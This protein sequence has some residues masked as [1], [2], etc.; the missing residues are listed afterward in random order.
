MTES[1]QILVA[2]SGIFVLGIG[3]QWI[4]SALKVPSI[5]LLLATGILFGPVLQWIQPNE[6]FGELLLPLVSMCV[7]IVL[8]EG[9]LSLRLEDL[10]KIGRPLAMLL[11][12]GVLITWA[13]CAMAANLILDFD[14]P[15]SLLI[16]SILTVTGPTVVGPLLGHIRPI[17]QVGP[18]ARWEGIVVD[19]IGAVLA[20]LVFQTFDAVQAAEFQ[21]A[22]SIGAIGFLKT[23]A[24]GGLIGT[25]GA[26]TIKQLLHRHLVTDHLQSPFVLM[27]VVATFAASN[28]LIHESGLVTVT[29]MGVILANQQT[30]SVK[31]IVEFKENLSVL[32]ISTL[33]I[34]LAAR[35]DLSQFQALSWRGPTFVLFVILVARPVSV[36]VS[37]I[38]CGLKHNER[39]FLSWLAPRGIVA[40]AVASVFALELGDG[41]DFVAATFLVIIGTVVVYGSTAGW[42]ARRLQLSVADP[43]GFVIA[44]AHGLGRRIAQALQ[45]SGVVVCLVDRSAQ[46]LKQARM[47]GLPTFYADILSEAVHNDLNLGGIG[48][49]LALLPNDEVNSLAAEH[50][51]PLF[52]RERV[53]RLMSPA[54]GQKRT[55]KSA[56]VLNGRP[57]FSRNATY[58]Q[59]TDRLRAGAEFSRTPLTE[60]FTFETFQ[61]RYGDDALVM[62]VIEDE[63][64]LV[65]TA[66]QDFTFRPGQ[67]L[68]ALVGG[69]G[70]EAAVESD[71]NNKK[72]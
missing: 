25:L 4:A 12:V 29:V 21:N 54:E 52:G 48:R 64:V 33:F 5:L 14:L 20:V 46:N 43:Q 57:L 44:G 6:L 67:T 39:I 32:L 22:A 60:E 72:T 2:L 53:Y 17:G 45:K 51:I 18:I 50:F 8:F 28:L 47:D 55:E 30:V 38:G 15:K 24:V 49:L 41:D 69:N 34:L 62:F 66:G 13:I 16:G 7:A 35:L 10:R 1:E 11:S 36:W 59:L 40:A 9:S 70:G 56:E 26:V 61:H 31:H 58:Q 3:S 68:V 23:L 71:D 27:L 42:L 63:R 65:M 37:T 19:P